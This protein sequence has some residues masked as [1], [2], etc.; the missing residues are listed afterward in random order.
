MI[1]YREKRKPG[2]GPRLAGDRLALNPTASGESSSGMTESWRAARPCGVR[3]R[4]LGRARQPGVRSRLPFN[5][6]P[7][8][9]GSFQ[10]EVAGAELI[11]QLEDASAA[12]GHAGERIV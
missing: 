3:D 4:I 5:P 10:P 7:G 2:D 8:R 11:H 1:A 12:A 6:A 9:P